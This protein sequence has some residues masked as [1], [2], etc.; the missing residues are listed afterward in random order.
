MLSKILVAG[1]LVLAA[2]EPAVAPK[3]EMWFFFFSSFTSCHFPCMPEQ[4]EQKQQR[5]APVAAVVDKKAEVKKREMWFFFFSACAPEQ[6]DQQSDKR[7]P[8]AN[9]I[10]KKAELKK[11]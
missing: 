5:V 3:R 1:A 9:A 6:M 7:N 8:V 10:E 11:R 2:A 4:M